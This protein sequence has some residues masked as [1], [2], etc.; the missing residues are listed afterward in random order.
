[1]SQMEKLEGLLRKIIREEIASAIPVIVESLRPASGL[2]APAPN[3]LPRMEAVPSVRDLL[4][5]HVGWEDGPPGD[6]APYGLPSS[7]MGGHQNSQGLLAPGQGG[8]MPDGKPVPPINE[9]TKP[10]YEAINTDYSEIMK[11]LNLV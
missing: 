9:A 7:P 11:K 10:V 2:M 5:Q 6:P 3:Q 1:M 4:E 8:Y